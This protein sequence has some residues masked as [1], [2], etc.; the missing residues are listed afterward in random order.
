MNRVRINQ[1]KVGVVTYKRDYNRLITAG[2]HW[3]SWGES[4]VLYDVSV[5]YS[6]DKDFDL[7]MRRP[8]FAGRVELIEVNDGELA[9]VQLHGAFVRLLEVGRYFFFKSHLEFKV[10]MIDITSTKQIAGWNSEL[11][12]RT[13]LV[14]HQ[15]VYAVEP[16]EKGLM[17]IDGDFVGLLD[18][19]IHRFWKNASVIQVF[20]ADMRQ[21]TQE[22][23]GQEIL[24]KDK[25]AIR[26]NFSTQ[27]HITDVQ[28]ALLENKDHEKQLYM[29][30]Q[31]ALRSYVG[32]LTLDEL[33]ENKESVSDYIVSRLKTEISDLGIAVDH[34]GIKDVI[35][36]GEMKEIM[37]Q[38]MIA[39]KQA[40]ANTITRREETASTRSL[41][42]TA[43]L[44]E[45][46][47]MLY[48]L[49]E[50]EYLERIADRIGDITVS[51]NGQVVDQLRQIFVK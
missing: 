35:L 44:M 4:Y 40:Q 22:V 27:Y 51:G 20:K 14:R 8:A 41:L 9:M 29:L 34:C 12:N 3:L 45:D 26:I 30:T 7:R 15:R 1:G 50:M 10:T 11:L 43:K 37:N 17:F 18:K 5:I 23:N 33:L 6:A 46:N 16:F 48:K 47:Q 31:L 25:A 24:T 28:K 38:V 42:N 21:M 39:Q 49:K 36:P 19:G 13:D 2:T 32:G